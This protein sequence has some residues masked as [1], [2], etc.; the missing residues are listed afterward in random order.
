MDEAE[1]VDRARN[2]DDDAYATLVTHYADL[3]FRTAW[4]ITGDAAEADDAAQAAFVKAYFALPRFRSGSP[5]RPW[6]LTIV[7]NEARNRRTAAGRRPM[8]DLASI[9]HLAISGSAVD[10]EEQAVRAE[11]E[12]R[13]ISVLNGLREED[14]T[15]IALR[16]FLDLTEAEMAAALDCRPGTV[17]SRLSRALARLRAAWPADWTW[18]DD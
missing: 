5:F 18:A 12:A 8:A 16:Y 14:R 1:V 7:A 4:V 11:R 9:E 17:K 3:A 2:G 15:V 13:L 10:P 6:L